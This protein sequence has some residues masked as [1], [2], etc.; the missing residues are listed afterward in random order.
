MCGY[1]GTVHEAGSIDD[2]MDWLGIKKSYPIG[3]SYPRKITQGLITCEQEGYQVSDALWW[4]QLK[5]QNG[6]HVVNEDITSFNAR[7]LN[8]P[9]WVEASR[10]RRGLV[11]A[12]ELG[13]SQGKNRYLMRS[14]EGFMLGAVYKDWQNADGSRLRS[15]AIITRPPHEAFKPYHEKS[16]P[17]F[18]PWDPTIIQDWLNPNLATS[19]VIE[20]LLARPKIT[21]DLEVTPV[22][23]YKRAEPIGSSTQI[24]SDIN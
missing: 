9:L 23:T 15:M 17:L 14:Q 8:R 12:T 18:I 1:F 24:P 4:Y 6:S 11:A 7:E 2:L 3:Q 10:T 22:K 20:D 13:E 16:T 19:P 21:T 5:P